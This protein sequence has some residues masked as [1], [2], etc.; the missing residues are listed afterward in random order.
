MAREGVTYSLPLTNY[1][2]IFCALDERARRLLFFL[3]LEDL[4]RC[5]LVFL[6]FTLG[7]LRFDLLLDLLTFFRFGIFTILVGTATGSS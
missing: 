2:A 3:D 1:F 5:F 6:D 4:T 7:A